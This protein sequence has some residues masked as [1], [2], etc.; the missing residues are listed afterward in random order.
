MQRG[1]RD[2]RDLIGALP[3]TEAAVA[4]AEQMHAGQH[5]R[6]DGAP[7]IAHPIEVATLLWRAG[8]PDHV[9]AA[10]V[11]HDVIEKADI[12]P[13]ELTRRFGRS[14]TALV[15]AVS[16]DKHIKGYAR[17]KAALRRQA[18]EAGD[19]AMMIFAADKISKVRE[20]ALEATPRAPARPRSPASRKRRLDHYRGCLAILETHFAT[21]PLVSQL[22]AELQ[23]LTALEPAAGPPALTAAG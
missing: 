18:I 13:A 1:G 4:Y 14:I 17:R 20:L 8:A 15:L 7:F 2:I 5:R 9:I 21:S 11:L 22:A 3:R 23:R 6:A 10:G 19:E 16:E 12:D